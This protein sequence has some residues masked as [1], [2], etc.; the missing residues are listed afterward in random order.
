LHA[1]VRNTRSDHRHKLRLSLIGHYGL[2]SVES[3]NIRGMARTRRLSRAISD[4]TWGGFAATLRHKAESAG[5][6]V[7][8]VNPAGTGQ[9]C[10]VCDQPCRNAGIAALIAVFP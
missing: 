2:I 6:R 7:V 9:N 10:S 1:K 4:V 8:G 5:A 3:L